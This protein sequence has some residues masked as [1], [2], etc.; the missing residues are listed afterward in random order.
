M[1]GI[2]K[3]EERL[4][5]KLETYE[6]NAYAGGFGAD[7]L[8]SVGEGFKFYIQR[9]VASGE[10]PS[11]AGFEGYIDMHLAAEHRTT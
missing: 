2:D 7:W 5:K 6:K 8:E 11:I 10:I 1:N 4:L 9:C 3:Y